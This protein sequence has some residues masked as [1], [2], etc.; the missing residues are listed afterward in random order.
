MTSSTR[1][2]AVRSFLEE[3]HRAVLATVGPRGPHLVVVDY[4]VL[5]DRILLNGRRDRRWVENLRLD[6]R[7]SALVHDPADVGHWVSVAGPVELLREGDEQAVE[8]AKTMSRRY[9]DDP[10]QFDGQHRVSWCLLAEQVV[11]RF[12]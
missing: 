8:D 12:A 7:A 2:A 5:D 3:K 11:E 6:P 4:L 1:L 9:G 10:A